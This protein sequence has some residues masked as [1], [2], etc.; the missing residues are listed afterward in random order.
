MRRRIA[1]LLT[2]LAAVLV[3]L[4]VPTAPAHADT[5]PSNPTRACVDRGGVKYCAEAHESD[6]YVRGSAAAYD[7][8]GG[9]TWRVQVSSIALRRVDIACRFRW[10]YGGVR[11]IPYP[12]LASASTP[13][14]ARVPGNPYRTVVTFKSVSGSQ[15]IWT[16]VRSQIPS[17]IC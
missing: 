17:S 11:P 16:T 5:Y 4:G 9:A 15:T 10:D 2:A 8:P 3:T 7:I 12:V 13:R 14:Q 1:P 6:A